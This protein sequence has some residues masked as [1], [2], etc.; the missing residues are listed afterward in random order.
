M[1][2]K[3]VF[4]LALIILSLFTG[5]FHCHDL[6]HTDEQSDCVSC[7]YQKQRITISSTVEITPS[8]L[9]YSEINSFI[10]KAPSHFILTDQE[11]RAP[12]LIL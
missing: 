4:I 11:S 6:A 9:I 2:K 8:I 12:P 10:K 5:L 3:H 1:Q 7:D